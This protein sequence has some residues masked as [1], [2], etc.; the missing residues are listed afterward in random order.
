MKR[1]LEE[2][3]EEYLPGIRDLKDNCSDRAKAQQWTNWMKQRWCDR[4]LVELRQQ[5]EPMNLTRSAIK[6][7]DPNHVALES[8][9][10]TKEE[11]FEVNLSS[12]RAVA[13]RNES[14]QLILSP[15]D[16]VARA[17][18][19]LD[20][21]NWY[22]IAAGLA[23]LTGRRSSEILKTAV[24]EGKSAFSV[25]FTGALKRRGERSVLCFEI[26]TLAEACLVMAA[27]ERVRE[28]VDTTG[29]DNR[30]VN[31]RFGDAVARA[32]DRHFRDLVPV[33]EGKDNL[34][35]HLFRCVFARIAT[36]YYA[37]PTL[38]DIEEIRLLKI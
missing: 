2:L 6:E 38:S 37:P 1:W 13:E 15:D 16:V 34:Y 5:K 29:L 24:F 14:C 10:F 11:W 20:S 27:L 22:D 30:A 33:R 23:V 17:T 28:R 9:N 32:C 18:E 26:P 35:T 12:D 4:G 25:L 21:R 36:F 19:L 8:M 31:A 3:L 7:I